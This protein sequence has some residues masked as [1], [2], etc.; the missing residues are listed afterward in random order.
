M[1][2]RVC[3]VCVCDRFGASLRYLRAALKPSAV[4]RLMAGPFAKYVRSVA[5]VLK[6]WH[7]N[8]DMTQRIITEVLDIDTDRILRNNL[9]L[10]MQ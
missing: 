1:R 5:P 8:G 10:R 7:E 6:E 9:L 4:R 2:V 3:I